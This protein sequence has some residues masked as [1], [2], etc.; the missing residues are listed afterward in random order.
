MGATEEEIQRARGKARGQISFYGSTP[1]Y[2]GVLERHGYEALQP[3]LNRLSKEGKWLEMM[4]RID[5]A[6]F[7]L[8]A[9]SGTPAEVAEKLRVRNTF[10]DRTTLMLYNETDPDAVV[11]VIRQLSA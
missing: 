6:L 4:G 7:D 2:K 3:E 10:A 5:D 11:D 1:A 8:I 9:V